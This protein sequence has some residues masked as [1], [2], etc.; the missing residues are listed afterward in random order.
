MEKNT[1]LHFIVQLTIIIVSYQK[2]LPVPLVT[3]K[4]NRTDFSVSCN[5]KE[6]FSINNNVLPMDYCRLAESFDFSVLE[7]VYWKVHQ[8]KNFPNLNSSCQHFFPSLSYFQEL[9]FWLIVSVHLKRLIPP[10][11][12]IALLPMDPMKFGVVATIKKSPSVQIHLKSLHQHYKIIY[13]S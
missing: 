6:K 11:D 12:R 9:L 4:R 2:N 7:Q 1:G 10:V 3:K 5:L 8:T 13:F